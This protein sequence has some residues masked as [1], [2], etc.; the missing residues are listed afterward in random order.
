M[1]Y[2]T[3]PVA[4]FALMRDLNVG[5]SRPSRMTTLLDGARRASPCTVAVS[6]GRR[7]IGVA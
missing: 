2:E 7:V 4:A 5:Y 1:T 6:R 3:R